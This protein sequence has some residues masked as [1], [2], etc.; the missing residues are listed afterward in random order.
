M[1]NDDQTQEGVQTNQGEKRGSGG[2]EQNLRA[3]SLFSSCL[4]ALGL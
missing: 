2:E 3:S 1:E 4:G